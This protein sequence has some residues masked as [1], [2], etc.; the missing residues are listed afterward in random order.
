LL[1]REK[2]YINILKPKYN[3]ISIWITYH[4]K[5]KQKLKNSFVG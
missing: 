1:E 4:Q 3:K 2:Y 5:K